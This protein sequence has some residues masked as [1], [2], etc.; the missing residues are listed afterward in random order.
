MQKV[1]VVWNFQFFTL[2]EIQYS[3]PGQD[4][5]ILLPL[6]DKGNYYWSGWTKYV[7]VTWWTIHA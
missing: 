1:T 3:D 7:A 6:A 4:F 2:I 5:Q